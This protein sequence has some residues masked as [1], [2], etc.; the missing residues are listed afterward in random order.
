MYF[1]EEPI[2]YGSLETSLRKH[3]T[4]GGIKDVDGE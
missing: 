4:K 3:C 1:R 2:D